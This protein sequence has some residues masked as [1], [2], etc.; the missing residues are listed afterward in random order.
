MS[1]NV[2]DVMAFVNNH[3]ALMAAPGAWK[4]SAAVLEGPVPL[5]AGA[6][7]AV[8]GSGFADGVYQADADGR[9]PTLPDGAFEGTVW[10]LNPPGEFLALCE[11]IAQ[12][13]R[14]HPRGAQVAYGSHSR[15][16]N[17]GWEE[18]FRARLR[19]WRRMFGDV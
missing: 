5:H 8:R 2:A 18:E 1:P 13:A 12:W 4:A 10:L 14:E 16:E 17:R 3:F 19:P 6:W 15:G 9:F 7:I 11:E